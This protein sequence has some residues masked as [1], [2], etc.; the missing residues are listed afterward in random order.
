MEDTVMAHNTQ[1]LEEK[2]EAIRASYASGL[3]D[4]LGE[5]KAAADLVVQGDLDEDVSRALSV[6]HF[7][8]HSLAGS[9]PSFGF[10][11]LGNASRKLE[12]FCQS[13][14]DHDQPL[15]IHKR[16]ETAGYLDSVLQCHDPRARAG[17]RG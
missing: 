2:I 6:L 7:Q 1:T 4:R 5:L 10:E 13:L 3:D 17:Q 12:L 15:S 14:T 16:Q 8:A 9:A 11:A